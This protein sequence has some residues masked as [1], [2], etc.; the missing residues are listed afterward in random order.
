M[1]HVAVNRSFVIMAPD[2]TQFETSRVSKNTFY[3][4]EISKYHHIHTT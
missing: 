2:R 1:M 3:R 4:T